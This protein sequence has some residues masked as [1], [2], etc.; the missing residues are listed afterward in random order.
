MAPDFRDDDFEEDLHSEPPAARRDSARGKPGKQGL[1]FDTEGEPE[2]GA[3]SDPGARRKGHVAAP[4]PQPPA[5]KVTLVDLATHVFAL[6]AMLP[7]DPE[8]GQPDY[9]SF[10]ADAESALDTLRREGEALG[11][12]PADPQEA[13]YALAAFLDEAVNRSEWA[14]KST[15]REEPLSFKLHHDS[16]AGVGFFEHL[17]RL[18]GARKD[19]HEVYFGCLS[20]GFRGALWE[21][22]SRRRRI[23]EDELAIIRPRQ[24]LPNKSLRLF[25]TGYR[26]APDLHDV[27]RDPPKWWWPTS[28][29]LA[30]AAIGI[31]V[32]LFISAA[33]AP[34]QAKQEIMNINQQH[35]AAISA[36]PSGDDS[37]VPRR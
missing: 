16:N 33:E 2:P 37:A 36:A 29:V 14:F 26:G 15:W 4:R 10:R 30:L 18:G 34:E 19:V 8:Q 25:P 11:L 6:T 35:K 5:R 20:L 9:A 31:Y 23:I 13:A 28:I 1:R 24:V 7:L 32:L 12:D 22:D 21:E 3:E 27:G 17:K